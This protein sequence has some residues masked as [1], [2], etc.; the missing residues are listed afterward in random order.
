MGRYFKVIVGDII[1]FKE[2]EYIVISNMR[3][4]FSAIFLPYLLDKYLPINLEVFSEAISYSAN[5]KIIKRLFYNSS[6]SIFCKEDNCKFQ[7]LKLCN[8]CEFNK[9]KMEDII[10]F[11]TD[12]VFIKKGRYV[13][14]VIHTNL[15]ISEIKNDILEIDSIDLDEVDQCLK[16]YID[17]QYYKIS[18]NSK[19]NF[20]RVYDMIHDSE[21]FDI[22]KSKRNQIIKYSTNR[23]IFEKD[24]LN[25]YKR[26]S[27][28]LDSE[29]F[30]KYCNLCIFSNDCDN[31]KINKLKE[32]YENKG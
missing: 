1:L 30:D 20:K 5:Y 17:F 24:E 21:I 32:Y 25:T 19:S 10:Y 2:K 14:E 6:P 12:K 13:S 16:T 8:I 31:C 27:Y 4:G 15:R 23:G 18:F 26:N 9:I 28:I 29:D 7:N 22:I 11:P 3:D